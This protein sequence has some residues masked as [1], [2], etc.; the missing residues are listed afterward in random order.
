MARRRDRRMSLVTTS[1]PMDLRHPK[2][3]YAPVP[4]SNARLWN[5]S[6]CMVWFKPITQPP[7][8]HIVQAGRSWRSRGNK[9]QPLFC[10]GRTHTSKVPRC[11]HFCEK[12]CRRSCCCDSEKQQLA[13]NRARSAMRLDRA[14]AYRGHCARSAAT[15]SNHAILPLTESCQRPRAA[16]SPRTEAFRCARCTR[17]KP[18]DP[19]NSR[20]ALAQ[21]TP[22]EHMTAACTLEWSCDVF[23]T[24][25]AGPV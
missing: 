9:E 15:G 17:C 21:I 10:I 20:P 3:V 23:S 14:S 25:R 5:F 19:V 4:D 8:A 1:S 2:S 11:S 6:V 18:I 22:L 24:S 16:I 7:S 12:M 13:L